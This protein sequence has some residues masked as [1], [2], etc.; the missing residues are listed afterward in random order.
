MTACTI[1][2]FVAREHVNDLQR[3]ADRHRLAAKHRA[4]RRVR[5]TVPRLLARRVARVT[6]P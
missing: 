1:T 3:A 4:P 2:Y 5:L 6:T